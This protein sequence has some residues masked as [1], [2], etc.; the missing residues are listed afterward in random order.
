[1]MGLY[2]FTRDFNPLQY[3]GERVWQVG[4][5]KEMFTGQEVSRT[6]AAAELAIGVI[7]GKISKVTIDK[8]K[9]NITAEP[10]TPE[11][12]TP[13]K[14]VSSPSSETK[15]LTG[16]PEKLALTAPPEKILLPE[17]SKND[18]VVSFMGK[19]APK[20]YDNQLATLGAQG[21]RLWVSP[22]DDVSKISNRA[23]VVTGTGHAPGPLRSYLRGDDI[24][25]IAV[26]T[27]KVSMRLPTAADAGATKHFRPGGYAGVEHKGIWK[28][29][30]VREYVIDGGNPVPEGSVF[31]KFNPDGSWTVIRKY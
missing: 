21:K 30:N 3:F 5:G 10:V 24:Y 27:S 22:I 6:T 12:S 14:M 29:S 11:I 25:G 26:P 4:S 16:P 9:P 31:F 18:Y 23:G 1:M 20:Y 28:S 17:L 15:L 8:A 19:N 7:V 13:K 2:R